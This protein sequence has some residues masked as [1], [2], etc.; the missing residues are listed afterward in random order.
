MIVQFFS[1]K[2]PFWDPFLL[3]RHHLFNFDF[4]TKVSEISVYVP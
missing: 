2:G 3:K 1:K 4:E